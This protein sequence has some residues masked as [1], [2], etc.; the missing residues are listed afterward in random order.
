MLHFSLVARVDS[1]APF[2]IVLVH[3]TQPLMGPQSQ[4]KEPFI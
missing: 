3:K 4:E 1:L 2:Y